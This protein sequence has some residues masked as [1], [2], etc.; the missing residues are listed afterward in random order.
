MRF[1]GVTCNTARQ[2]RLTVGHSVH[3]ST[4]GLVRAILPPEMP[5]HSSTHSTCSL[6]KAQSIWKTLEKPSL[7]PVRISYRYLLLLSWAIKG[8]TWSQKCGFQSQPCSPWAASPGTALNLGFPVCKMGN[9]R[10]PS[11]QGLKTKRDEVCAAD[12][13]IIKCAHPLKSL[14]SSLGQ[15]VP[16]RSL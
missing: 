10:A 1:F 4:P 6:T 2:V 5:F 7:Q 3:L 11:S 14:L 9:M 13:E 8:R 16:C 15:W 12:L